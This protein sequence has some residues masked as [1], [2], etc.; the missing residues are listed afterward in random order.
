MY[1]IVDNVYLDWLCTVPP[2]GVSNNIDKS[3]WSKWLESMQKDVECTFEILKG[4]WRIL[5]SGVQLHGVEAVDSVWFAY[6]A[7]HNWLLEVDGLMDEWMGG[8]QQVMSNWEG[9]IGCLDFKGV[10]VK[11]PNALACLSE[12]LDSQNYDSLG[13]GPGSDVMAEN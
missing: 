8:V 3:W 7:L 6:C 9:D 12:N 2:F 13:L 5:K 4:R 11:V 10:Q 1:L